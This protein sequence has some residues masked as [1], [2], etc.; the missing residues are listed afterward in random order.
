MS[1]T[2]VS[3]GIDLGTTYSCVAVFENGKVEIIANEQGNRTTPSW[4][5]FTDEERLIGDAAKNASGQNYLNTIYEAKRMM[6]RDWTD[7]ILQNDLK[8]FPYKV[9]NVNNKPKVEVTF[10]GEPKQFTPEEIS[11]MILTK[12]KN[13]AESYL[14]KPVKNAVVTVPAYFNDAQRQATKDAGAIAGL[15]VLRVINEP[16]AAAIAYGLDKK[17]DGKGR[18]VLIFDCGGGTHD[19]SLLNIE[20]GIFEV[21]ATGG[22]THLGG[23]DIDNLIVD[24]LVSEFKQK[25]K[26]DLTS[27]KKAIKRLTAAAEKAKRNLSSST[28]TT[29]EIDSIH[30]GMDF[31]YSLTR[32]K[33]EN[34][35]ASIFQRTMAPVDQVLKDAKLS[36]SDVDEIVLVGGTTRIPKIRELLTTFFNGK[37][38]NNSVNPDEAVAYGA[39]VQAAILSGDKSDEIQDILLLDVNPLSLGVETAGSMMTV[40]IPRGT[41]IPTKKTQTFSTASDNQPGVTICVFEGERKLTRDCN[42]LGKFQLS[43]IPP[44]PRGMPQIEI[45]Y[46]VDANG[47]LQV[48]A[49][50]KSTGK[51]EKITISNTSNKLSKEQIE[52]MVKEAEEFKEQD[53]AIARK[54]EAKNKLEGYVY[55][56]KSSVLGDE[57]MKT[58]IGAEVDTVQNTIDEAIKW[59]DDS[60]ERTQEDYEAK[61]KEVEAVLMP[62]IQKAY[63]SNMPAGSG[64]P[65][66]MDMPAQEGPGPKIEEV[67]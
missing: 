9:V 28:V 53:E 54:V 40:L 58:S 35:C 62:I 46:E 39:A 61:Q 13:I 29:V 4:V 41:T 19:V 33:F 31:S 36:K 43:N 16:T 63:Q 25:N 26:V 57:K 10:K 3:I 64:M 42:Q 24:F 6:G 30:D 5:S 12:M 48:S 47:I 52:K 8:L 55:N 14:G 17:K 34:I 37:E 18:N 1:Q 60:T 32:A 45:T 66:G 50:E 23:A 22:D 2:Q 20:D 11:A 38:L 7:P 44:M 56:V 49:V 21:K 65:G 15:N 59:L 27:N 51:S 67:D